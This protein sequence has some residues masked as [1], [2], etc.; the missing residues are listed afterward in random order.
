[1][2]VWLWVA[3]VF[4]LSAGCE[5]LNKPAPGSDFNGDGRVDF[6][7]L[8]HPGPLTPQEPNY[9][10]RDF[11]QRLQHTMDRQSL[12]YRERVRKGQIVD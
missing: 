7:D 1:M 10:T 6:R 5:Q 4:V 3:V 2:R 12:D 8:D 9:D 11:D